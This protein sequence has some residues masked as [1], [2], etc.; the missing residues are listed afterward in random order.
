M[1]KENVR[2]KIYGWFKKKKIKIR[3]NDNILKDKILDSFDIIDFITFVENSFS[4]KFDKE[5]LQDV[6]LLKI[7]KFIKL[8]EKKVSVRI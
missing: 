7:K 8:I 3:E 4:I 2:T 5:E 6:S 1:N